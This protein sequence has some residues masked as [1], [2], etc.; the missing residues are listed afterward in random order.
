MK[1]GPFVVCLKSKHLCNYVILF[2]VA[3]WYG[4]IF[5]RSGIYEGGM[6]RFT[7]TLPDKFPDDEVPVSTYCAH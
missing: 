6:F 3:V 4:V 7:L 2:F 5:V 1:T